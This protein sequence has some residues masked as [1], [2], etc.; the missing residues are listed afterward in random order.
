VKN[1]AVQSFMLIRASLSASRYRRLAAALAYRSVEDLLGDLGR[2]LC[3]DIFH[4]SDDYRVEP[5]EFL[6][7]GRPHVRVD[8]CLFS[9]RQADRDGCFLSRLLTIYVVIRREGL[10]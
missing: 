7:I 2:P 10:R 5:E 6:E 1:L 8:F 3:A 4:A 9:R